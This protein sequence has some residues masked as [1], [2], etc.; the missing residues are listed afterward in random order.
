MGNHW[1]CA[2]YN[3]HMNNLFLFKVILFLLQIL[4]LLSTR[5]VAEKLVTILLYFWEQN[6]NFK[7]RPAERALLSSACANFHLLWHSVLH[8]KLMGILPSLCIY[9]HALEVDHV[10][11][12]FLL[13]QCVIKQTVSC[14]S[15]DILIKLNFF[16]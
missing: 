8:N 13:E 15:Q 3:I 5:L 2:S 4:F 9:S 11:A 7:R 6:E 10:L 14:N 1:T 12:A 16:F